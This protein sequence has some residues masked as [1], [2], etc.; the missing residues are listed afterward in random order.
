MYKFEIELR[1]LFY[2]RTGRSNFTT[3]QEKLFQ[4]L[5]D[6]DSI[7][8]ALADKGLG[9]VAVNL[10]R[11]IQDG[12]IHLKDSDT[13]EIISEEQAFKEARELYN[14]IFDWTSKHFDNP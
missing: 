9:P 6:D 2:N 8:F 7:D 1:R 10:D 13:Y 4:R 14:T 12:L 11:Y 3:F 5:R